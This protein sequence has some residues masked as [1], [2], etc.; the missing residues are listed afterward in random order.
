MFLF[1]IATAVHSVLSGALTVG[2][3]PA[4][5]VTIALKDQAGAVTLAVVSAGRYTVEVQPGTYELVLERAI[6]KET[7][8]V[9]VPQF[10]IEEGR[11]GLDIPWPEGGSD[12]E[13][14]AALKAAYDEG[15]AD[16]SSGRYK[17]SLDAF[18]KALRVDFAQPQIWG[19]MA[20][21]HVGLKEF[22]KALDSGRMAVRFGPD[23]AVYRNNLGATYFRVGQYREAAECF[24]EA[25]RLNS[26]GVGM[27]CANAGAAYLWAGDEKAALE[28]YGR[29]VED[30]NAPL[31]AYFHYGAL[32]QRRGDPGGAARMFEK[33]LQI[34]PNG[35]RAQDVRAR[36]KALGR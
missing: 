24:L 3:V 13:R 19:S 7:R 16:L 11:I 31:E 8:T 27:Y 17:A 29:S 15:T 5:G 18:E 20:L 34:A 12:E 25:A 10:A 9:R 21:A 22:D 33:Y 36:L 6:G 30:P 32:M 4:E 14:R 1:T 28:C 26:A 35:P 23:Q 2:G